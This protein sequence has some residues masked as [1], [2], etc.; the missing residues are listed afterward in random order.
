MIETELHA[1]LTSHGLDIRKVKAW[2]RAY[3]PFRLGG[4][5]RPLFSAELDCDPPV[6]AGKGFF[7]QVAHGPDGITLVVDPISGGIVGDTLEQVQEDIAA[8]D[9][10]GL[11][12]TQ[13]D[14]AKAEVDK[15]GVE[16]LDVAEFWDLIKGKSKRVML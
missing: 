9:D 1:N 10:I 8:C 2:T 13:I 3:L 11:M 12:K 5:L 15:E 4:N 16:N 14:D 6:D 7:V